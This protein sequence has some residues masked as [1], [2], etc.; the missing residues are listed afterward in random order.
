M[1][2]YLV[3]L[4]VDAPMEAVE[5]LKEGLLKHNKI[6]ALLLMDGKLRPSEPIGQHDWGA[7]RGCLPSIEA[8]RRVGEMIAGRAGRLL[9]DLHLSLDYAWKR[10]SADAYLQWAEELDIDREVVDFVLRTIFKDA[11]EVGK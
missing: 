3:D 6:L 7:W 8:A 4:L 10:R 5:L 11:D 1:I 2:D 9:V